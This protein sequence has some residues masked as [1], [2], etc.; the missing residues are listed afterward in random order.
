MGKVIALHDFNGTIL[1]P[2]L[3][4]KMQIVPKE[5]P[6]S[7]KRSRSRSGSKSRSNSRKTNKEKDMKHGQLSSSKADSSKDPVVNSTVEVDKTSRT[8]KV[9]YKY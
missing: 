5:K 4:P 9:R 7:R 3:P 8:V 1:E 6:K 2:L